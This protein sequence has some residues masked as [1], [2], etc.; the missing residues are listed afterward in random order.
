MTEHTPTATEPTESPALRLLRIGWNSQL[1]R[2]ATGAPVL[3]SSFVAEQGQF[4]RIVDVR[5]EAELTGPLGHIPQ[6]T[7]VP[8]ER[9]SEVAKRL[10]R[11]TFVVL[12]SSGGERAAVAARYL[13]ALGMP[14]VAALD[15]G[16]RSYKEQGYGT[17]RTTGTYRCELHVLAPGIGRDGR[18][19]KE[20]VTEASGPPTAAEVEAHLADAARVR[21]IKLAA[22]VLHGRRS[23]VDGRDDRGVI[24]T[25]GGDAGEF[26]L[27]LAALERTTGRALSDRDVARELERHVDAFGRFYLH[28]DT[29]AMNRLIVEGLRKDDRVTPHLGSVFE[30]AEWRAWFLRP[31]VAARAA[32]LEHL[33]RP[34][35]MGCGHLR[36]A[37]TESSDYGV[38]PELA[39]SFLRAFHEL[40]WAGAPELEWAV[41]GG[42]HAESGVASIVVA[43]ELHGTTRIPLIS[44]LVAGRQ[45][46]VNHP[47]VTAHLRREQ[48]AWLA[49]GALA[50][51]VDA[52]ELLA[53][54]QELGGQQTQA[55]LGRLARGLPVFELLFEPDGLPR[56]RE[57]GEVG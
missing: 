21:W 43:G 51:S 44:P 38:R 7:H 5:E 42:D 4:V 47:Q 25:P 2:D 36:F 37:M 40:R 26:L 24:G 33:M 22:L 14:H 28:S 39:A 34:S 6:V 35:N 46:F 48:A 29:H 8:L 20:T 10:G 30:A 12:I 50:G 15:G 54:M 32:L 52:S 18:P 57:L 9:V 27:G 13:E 53:T 45:L 1:R 11:D 19:L 56:V 31:P 17:L 23:C 3:P 55:T 41:L 16:M 49:S